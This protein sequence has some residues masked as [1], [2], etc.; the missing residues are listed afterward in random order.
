MVIHLSKTSKLAKKRENCELVVLMDEWR[1]KP[2]DLGFTFVKSAHNII[3]L[4]FQSRCL[5]S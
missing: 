4:F 1:F 5:R 3:K 2:G